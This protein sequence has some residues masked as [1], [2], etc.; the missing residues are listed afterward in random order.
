M[1]LNI[2]QQRFVDE[3]L[4]DL[5]ATQAAIRAGYSVKTAGSQ[6]GRLIKSGPV[7][8]AIKVA[9]AERSRRTGITADRVLREY[10]RIAFAKV[11]DIIGWDAQGNVQLRASVDISEDDA[12][13][14][15]E[16]TQTPTPHGMKLSVKLHS[17]D[18]ALR[19]LSAHLGIG[20]SNTGSVDATRLIGGDTDPEVDDRGEI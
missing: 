16:V 6:G 8:D 1:P 3:Y 19:A 15:A 12:A 7:A 13:A 10:A 18:A 11:P 17:K 14:I 4:C 20:H 9:L 5:N 2:Q